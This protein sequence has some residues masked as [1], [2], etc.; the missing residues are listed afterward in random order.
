M[1]KPKAF[2]AAISTWPLPDTI[3]FSALQMQP[4]E[5]GSISR[6]FQVPWRYCN[7]DSKADIWVMTETFTKPLR[8]WDLL[9]VFLMDMNI[10]LKFSNKMQVLILNPEVSVAK[11]KLKGDH[12][13]CLVNL[14]WQ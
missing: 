12:A 1:S 9:I 3:L 6:V 14:L 11:W 10:D 4:N 2:T 13:V 7:K 5:Q 8:N